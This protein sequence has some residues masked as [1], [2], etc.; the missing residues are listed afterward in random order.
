MNFAEAEFADFL[1]MKSRPVTFVFCKTVLGIFFIVFFHHITKRRFFNTTGI[2]KEA[3]CS[4]FF[5]KKR[6]L[7][8][9]PPGF[10]SFY[11]MSIIVRILPLFKIASPFI[12]P[13]TNLAMGAWLEI[14]KTLSFP[15]SADTPPPSATSRY[16]LRDSVS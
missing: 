6:T 8:C 13:T 14:T 5:S 16:I 12:L 10:G 4:L 7:R 9:F 15:I 1:H 11:F 3:Y 2:K